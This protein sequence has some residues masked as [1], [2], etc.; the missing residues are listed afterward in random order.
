MEAPATYHSVH[1]E[2]TMDQN[3]RWPSGV[4]LVVLVVLVQ[5]WARRR[6][7]ERTDRCIETQTD[8]QTSLPPTHAYGPRLSRTLSLDAPHHDWPATSPVS[9]AILNLQS[10][11]S[12][13][14]RVVSAAS[15]PGCM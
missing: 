12:V 10:C 2:I 6:G 15:S 8:G 4:G 13:K 3:D 11:L 7:V 5:M 9:S 14:G 1:A